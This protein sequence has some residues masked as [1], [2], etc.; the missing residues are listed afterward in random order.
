MKIYCSIGRRENS[1]IEKSPKI[2]KNLVTIDY[3]KY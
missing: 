3:Y 1:K 2:N